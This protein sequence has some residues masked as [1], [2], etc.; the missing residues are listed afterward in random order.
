MENVSIIFCSHFSP[1]LNC[2]TIFHDSIT[3]INLCGFSLALHERQLQEIQRKDPPMLTMDE[4]KDSVAAVRALSDI[5]QHDKQE[6]E[7][8]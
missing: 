3:I 7:V 2:I 1:V 8:T 4:M 5:L 6:A